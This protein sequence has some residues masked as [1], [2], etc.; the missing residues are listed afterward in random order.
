MNTYFERVV[1]DAILERTHQGAALLTAVE[2]VLYCGGEGRYRV[3][4]CTLQK[5]T[6][7]LIAPDH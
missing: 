2:V 7:D 6:R 4:R 1:A 5:N 3:L